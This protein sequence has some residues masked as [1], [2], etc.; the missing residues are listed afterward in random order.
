MHVFVG[1][2]QWL[3]AQLSGALVLVFL[4]L[5]RLAEHAV[6]GFLGKLWRGQLVREQ[7]GINIL[8][9]SLLLD[10]I[11]EL[12]FWKID[13]P[14]PGPGHFIRSVSL[15]HHHRYYLISSSLGNPGVARVPD[16][17]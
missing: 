14:G 15:T 11:P 6:R 3:R 10:I 4:V 8:F 7:R 16:L 12:F 5:A 17:R 13:K 1:N 9:F 2:L